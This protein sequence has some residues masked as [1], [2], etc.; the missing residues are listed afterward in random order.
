MR[1]GI[2]ARILDFG[3]TGIG[4]YLRNL[5]DELPKVDT[6]NEYFLFTNSN[7]YINSDFYTVVNY[8]KNS[9][10]RVIYSQIYSFFD[11]PKLLKEYKID[12]LFAANFLI[13]HRG[14]KKIK[15]VS[16][17]Y[18]LLPW[19]LK[20]SGSFIFRVFMKVSV[21]FTVKR[22]NKIITISHHS[23]KDIIK[24]LK[25]PGEKIDVLYCTPAK[26]IL[27]ERYKNNTLSESLK[28][29]LPEKYL[30]YVGR[31]EARKNILTILK[32]LDLLKQKGSDLKLVLVGAKGNGFEKIQREIALRDKTV[33]YLTKLDD[34]I[35]SAIYKKAFAFI[36]P[37]FYEGFGFTPLEA[38]TLGLPVLTS[39]TSSLPE[40]VGDAGIMHSPN[41]SQSFAESIMRL[42]NDEELYDQM[43]AK[44][45][46]Q[47]DKFQINEI[48]K[49]LVNIFNELNLNDTSR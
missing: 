7:D 35:L 2:D 48:T 26:S 19:I 8:R 27:Q 33:L 14:M 6:E 3:Y 10:P 45:L 31:I 47:S 12:L 18:D 23:K 16:V 41:D 30:L 29:Q 15:S 34:K 42:E 40:V 13:P 21:P 24:L 38:M 37:S 11:L 17:I 4:R 46:V 22:V 49:E 28:E 44:S 39:N 25:V 20:E 43:K 5:L 1:I 32:I 9:L 36:F